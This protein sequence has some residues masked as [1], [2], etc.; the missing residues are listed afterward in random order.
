[1]DLIA[2]GEGVGAQF[3]RR[4]DFEVDLMRRA[5]RL[6][7]GIEPLARP[8]E[9]AAQLMD[10]DTGLVGVEATVGGLEL[11]LEGVGRDEPCALLVVV[12]P[13]AQGLADG[14]VTR[15]GAPS[16]GRAP[17]EHAI[18][19]LEQVL[20]QADTDNPRRVLGG[21]GHRFP[22]FPLSHYTM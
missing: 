4:A 20:R 14:G 1:M 18:K 10:G 2:V 6:E 8:R 11:L 5:P 19:A 16:S 22:S 15:R 21:S 7:D 17:V 12:E 13:G 9:Q 3:V